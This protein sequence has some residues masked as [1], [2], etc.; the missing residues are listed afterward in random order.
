M[1]LQFQSIATVAGDLTITSP[2]ILMSPFLR[3]LATGKMPLLSPRSRS[4]GLNPYPT[5][6]HP[7][8]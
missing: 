4:S 8:G 1:N 6:V 2:A 5:K 7:S 3:F